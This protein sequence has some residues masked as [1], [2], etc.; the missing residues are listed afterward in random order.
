MKNKYKMGLKGF[1][2]RQQE[3]Y[4]IIGF[5]YIDDTYELLEYQLYKM[6]INKVSLI[7]VVDF[8]HHKQT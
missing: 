5:V 3:T 1:L 7:Y 4:E 8:F 2:D 6:F